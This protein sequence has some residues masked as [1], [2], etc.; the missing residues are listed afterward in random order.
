[1]KEKFIVHP[2]PQ[3]EKEYE[4][5]I[6]ELTTSLIQRLD[7]LSQKLNWSQSELITEALEFALDHMETERN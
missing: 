2:C 5:I 1:M 6:V 3:T 7:V 4:F